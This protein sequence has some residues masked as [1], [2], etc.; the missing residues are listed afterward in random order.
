MRDIGRRNRPRSGSDRCLK[1]GGGFRLWQRLLRF[2]RAC[3]R[4]WGFGL[5]CLSCELSFRGLSSKPVRHLGVV[6]ICVDCPPFKT[7][8]FC[9][10]LSQRSMRLRKQNQHQSKCR[11]FLPQTRHAVP[12]AECWTNC[13]SGNLPAQVCPV[14]FIGTRV[15]DTT[16][17]LE[18]LQLISRSEQCKRS[19]CPDR[20][21]LGETIS[22]QSAGAIAFRRPGNQIGRGHTF[23]I[24]AAWAEA[25]TVTSRA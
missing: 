24:C 12:K 2:S 7:G 25:N 5:F 23:E 14:V 6:W 11:Q 13:P 4:H 21:R 1:L 18:R 22:A 9:R 8:R 19:H 20:K 3:F 10:T 17:Q 15:T 16:G